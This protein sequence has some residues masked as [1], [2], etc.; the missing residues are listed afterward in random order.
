[1]KRTFEHRKINLPQGPRLLTEEIFDEHSDRQTLWKA[2]LT[3]GG[4]K[5]AP[6]KLATIAKEIEKFLIEPLGALNKGIKFGKEWKAP[7]PWK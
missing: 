2:F 7:G 6:D 1:M 3:K 5:H 4:I